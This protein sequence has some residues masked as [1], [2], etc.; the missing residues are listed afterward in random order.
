MA[1]SSACRHVVVEFFDARQCAAESFEFA[2]CD[3][4]RRVRQRRGPSSGRGR[5]WR[6]CSGKPVPQSFWLGMV[7]AEAEQAAAA[8][9]ADG[10]AH[11]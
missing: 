2:G 5:D 7:A 3:F 1:A 10:V 4:V 6:S 11:T 8:V 9:F